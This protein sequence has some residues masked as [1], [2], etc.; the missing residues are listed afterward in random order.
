MYQSVC[1]ERIAIRDGRAHWGIQEELNA[2]GMSAMSGEMERGDATL[3]GVQWT[4]SFF[5]QDAY[6]SYSSV[7]RCDVHGCVA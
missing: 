6:S 7:F 2:G 3:I 4:R 1:S 5:E